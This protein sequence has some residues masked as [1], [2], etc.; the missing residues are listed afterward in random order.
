MNIIK[1]MLSN[2]LPNAF[3]VE[4]SQALD[5]Q[6]REGSGMPKNGQIQGVA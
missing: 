2:H 1:K 6:I 4:L 3:Q 5:F